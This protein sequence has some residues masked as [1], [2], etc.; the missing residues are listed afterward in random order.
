MQT[1]IAY[2]LMV[3][4]KF[5]LVNFYQSFFNKNKE[6]KKKYLWRFAQI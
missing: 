3:T 5:S 1:G 2:N 4:N 6:K